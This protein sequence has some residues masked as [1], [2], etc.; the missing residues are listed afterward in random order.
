MA[1]TCHC[2]GFRHNR[3]RSTG[4]RGGPCRAFINAAVPLMQDVVEL[5]MTSRGAGR[6]LVAAAPRRNCVQR[7]WNLLG[8]T[9]AAQT[10]LTVQ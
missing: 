3:W 5:L 8:T 9:V 1:N 10:W 4:D 2:N 7:S 6:N